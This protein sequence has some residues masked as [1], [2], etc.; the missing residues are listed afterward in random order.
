M[1]TAD[2]DDNGLSRARDRPLLFKCLCNH[3]AVIDHLSFAECA[4]FVGCAFA[5][6]RTVL[7]GGNV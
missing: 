5:D 7:G 1:P 4:G 2:M 3:L 6:V